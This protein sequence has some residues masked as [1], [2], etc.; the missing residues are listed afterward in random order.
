MLP[1]AVALLDELLSILLDVPLLSIYR[2]AEIVF[3]ESAVLTIR[4]HVTIVTESRQ[5]S[6]SGR[7]LEKARPSIVRS[8]AVSILLVDVVSAAERVERFLEA[9]A[10]AGENRRIAQRVAGALG[11]AKRHH[12]IQEVFRFIA[13]KRHDPF[14]VIQPE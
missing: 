1:S 9:L 4:E 12:E 11:F 5:R 7:V 3:P 6:L 2:C 14:L 8:K 13:F 10:N